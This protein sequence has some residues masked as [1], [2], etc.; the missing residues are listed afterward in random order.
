MT[1]IETVL[2]IAADS[3]KKDVRGFDYLGVTSP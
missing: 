2:S 3:P 1:A